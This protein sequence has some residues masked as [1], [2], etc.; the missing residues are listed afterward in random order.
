M[1][2]VLVVLFL[3]FV[4]FT[5]HAQEMKGEFVSLQKDIE[6]ASE[7]FSTTLDKFGGNN[8]DVEA[9]YKFEEFER[10]FTSLNRQMLD[11][12]SRLKLELL[13][14]DTAKI[15]RLHRELRRANKRMDEL[16]AEYDEWIS[17]LE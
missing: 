17:S 14:R 8:S 16:K 13:R 3:S 15:D 5:I 12:D 4:A 11:M 9:Y 2:T 7:R 1:R 10:R 6:A